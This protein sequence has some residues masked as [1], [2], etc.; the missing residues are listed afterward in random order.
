M[1]AVAEFMPERDEGG[2]IVIGSNAKPCPFCGADPVITYSGCGKLAWI[3]TPVSCC[4]KQF[5]LRDPQGYRA[6]KSQGRYR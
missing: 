3:H 4:D 6:A 2:R 5:Q 1:R